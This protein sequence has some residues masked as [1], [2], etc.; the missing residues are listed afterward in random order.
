[1]GLLFKKNKTYKREVACVI[2]VFLGY[3]AVVGKTEELKVLVWPG[4][5]YVGAAFGMAW[6]TKQTTLTSQVFDNG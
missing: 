4:M 3:L 6:A 1:M 5:L 2:L